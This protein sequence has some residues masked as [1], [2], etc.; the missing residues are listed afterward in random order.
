VL[1]Y[2]DNQKLWYDL[3]RAGLTDHTPE[4]LCEV[5][6]SDVIFHGA[7]AVLTQYYFLEPSSTL[8]V[9][10]MHNCVHDWT[11]AALNKDI[12][13]K[14]YWYAFDCVDAQMHTSQELMASRLSTSLSLDSLAM[15]RG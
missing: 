15:Q 11:L 1:A 6:R 13:I 14:H 7:M 4:W 5:V 2:F 8:G 10:S 3:F 9:W 12:D